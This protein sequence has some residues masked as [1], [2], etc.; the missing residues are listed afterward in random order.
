[1]L[2][3]WRPHLVPCSHA[4]MGY[5]PG[6]SSRERN[7]IDLR[8]TH[9]GTPGESHGLSIWRQSRGKISKLTVNRRGSQAPL[10]SC[11][12]RKNHDASWTIRRA[13]VREHQRSSVSHP[14]WVARVTERAY[15]IGE[16]A[17]RP[18]QCWNDEDPTPAVITAAKGNL[19]PVRRPVR[20]ADETAS[21][22]GQPEWSFLAHQLHI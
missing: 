20:A 18:T 16:F 12:Q 8:Q 1:M 15:H 10:L 14:L 5:L 2:S 11:L 22:V 3:I 6:L 13:T 9:R 19:P 17:L 4:F 7:G 21:G